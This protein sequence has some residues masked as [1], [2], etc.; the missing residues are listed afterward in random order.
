MNIE[1]VYWDHSYNTTLLLNLIIVI[2]LFTS[3]RLFSGT[4][5]HI[6]ASDE[7]F[8]K[9]NPAF[10][11]SVAAVTFAI[12]ILL[13]GT[14]YG[15]PDG[16]MIESAVSIGAY[17]IAG[18]ILMAVARIVFDKMALPNVS[19]RNE[20]RKGNMAVAIADAGNVIASAIIIREIMIWITDNTLDALVALIIAYVVSQAILT[21]TTV[22]R[23]KMF[24][25]AHAGKS[26]QKEL[27]EGNIALALSFAGRKIGTAFAI[28]MA[29]NLVVYEIYEIQSILVPWII[30]SVLII[31]LLKL[32]S[33][34][35]EKIILFQVD[36]SDEV[37][38]QKNM[39]VGALQA[40]IYISIAI[41]LAEL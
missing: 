36:T 13:S 39:A 16:N 18:I 24:S 4:I 26:L 6:N 17:G 20:I 33:F 9:D 15:D 14:V 38:E 29:V 19:L 32:L 35:A 5:A 11:L 1:L 27:E 12:T 22:L 40:V 25:F 8:K 37:L 41:L 28:G 34:V 10:G 7:L 23:R 3:L 31:L 21:V 30:I 2:A